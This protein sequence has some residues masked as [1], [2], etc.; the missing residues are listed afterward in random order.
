MSRPS[1]KPETKIFLAMFLVGFVFVAYTQRAWED[2]WITFRASRNL[3]TGHGLV[4]TLGE[5]VH[6][7]TS[8][9][10]VLL[11][12]GLSWLTGN[13][14]EE[15][16]L[17]LFRIVSLAA[18]AAGMAMLFPILKQS[19]QR[20]V[21]IGATLALVALDAKTLDFSTNGMETGLLIFFL[22]L[23][24]HGFFISGPK[25]ILRIGLGWAGLMW[26]RPDSCVYIAAL[27][28]GALLF[29]RR[30]PAGSRA[31]NW[32]PGLLR[33]GLICAVLYLPWFLWAWWYYGSPVPHTIVAKATNAPP[34]A[35][36][37]LPVNFL[38][39]PFRSLLN[40]HA[41]IW[42]TFMPAYSVMRTWYYLP[43]AVCA[44][45]SWVA[46]L[47]WLCPLCRPSAR[48]L[49]F[50]VYVGHYFLSDVVRDYYPWYLPPVAFLSYLT[51]GLIVD[52]LLGL[53]E[54]LPQLNWNRG[55]LRHST[56]VLNG[57]VMVLVVSELGLTVCV[58]RQA[59]IQ[60]RLIEDGV[61]RPIGLWLRAHAA[62]SHDTVMLEP[63]GYIGYYSGLKMLD[64]PGLS[65]KEM[66][67]VRRR[68]GPEKEAEAYLELKP[69]WLVLRPDEVAGKWFID[70]SRLT[71]FYDVVAV[72]DV[73]DQLR[74]IRWLPARNNLE[75]DQKYLIFHR[76]AAEQPKP[77][78]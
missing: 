16:V 18:L 55:W 26:T 30:G 46:A 5:R 12:A 2:Y 58:A 61:R 70:P 1:L 49:S 44:L 19:I 52:Q 68:L 73:S 20:P 75:V 21:A 32:W 13:G 71:E 23:A 4:Y 41:S 40:A 29:L 22:S 14:P 36:T 6:T 56:A 59:Q 78:N 37:A 15:L 51:L 17:W 54:R 28:I 74:A 24:L 76:K 62:S 43:T 27:G 60:Q 33:A 67:E 8:P 69:D 35:I 64:Y 42:W 47:V 57:V 48:M 53:A 10:G 9:L 63:L 72:M 25:Q 45:A 66:V 31:E 3:A 77:S 7:F 38:S 11:P 39:L 50:C 65:S 34:M